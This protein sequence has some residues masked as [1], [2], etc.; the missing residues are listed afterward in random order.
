MLEGSILYAA[1]R[2]CRWW[3]T[4]GSEA[5]QTGSARATLTHPTR[6]R[7]VSPL[8]LCRRAAKLRWQRVLGAVMIGHEIGRVVVGGRPRTFGQHGGAP[9]F[10]IRLEALEYVLVALLEIAALAR[11]LHHV[12]Q[13]LVASDL[14]VLPV[15]LAQRALLSGL[16]A[17]IELAGVGGRAACHDRQ[18]V[19]AVGRVRRVRRGAG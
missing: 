7:S 19:L 1:T 14:E 12:E 13:E 15:A 6:R 8:R 16:E 2:T 9:L 17:P 18:Q 11:I 5:N 10:P 4:R 3:V